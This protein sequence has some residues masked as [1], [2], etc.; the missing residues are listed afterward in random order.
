[1]EHV[2]GKPEGSPFDFNKPITCPAC[3]TLL[4]ENLRVQY[5]KACEKYGTVYD[6]R[7]ISDLLRRYE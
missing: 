7:N 3:E 6:E 2:H 5:A 1:M 4:A